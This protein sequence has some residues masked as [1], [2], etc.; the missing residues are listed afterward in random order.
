MKHCLKTI[1]G[2][3]EVLFEKSKRAKRLSITV[4]PFKRVRVAVPKNVSYEKASQFLDSNIAWLEKKIDEVKGIE[5]HHLTTLNKRPAIDKTKAANLLK[6]KLDWL[7]AKFG[8]EYRK[9]FIRNQK[10]RWGS[11]SE[12][13]N[14]N[15]NVN[16]IN[17]TNDLIDYVILHELVHT[18]IKDHSI[19]FWAELN[20][21]VRN[22]KTID[23][24]LA[25]H[26]LGLRTQ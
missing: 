21:Y 8:F 5:Y 25:K 1:P 16:L 26:C 4:R 23:K 15:L 13:N 22:A 10:T 12:V 11:C 7:A 6:Q 9:V 14:I 3:G 20:K 17:L 19:K 2:I 18:K 24:K